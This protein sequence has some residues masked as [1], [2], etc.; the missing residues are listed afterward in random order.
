MPIETQTER[1]AL[2]R[3]MSLAKYQDAKLSIAE[4]DTFKRI[5]E[6]IGWDSGT[7]IDIF[8]DDATGRARE[9]LISDDATAAF[10]DEQTKA[11]TDA[12]ARQTSLSKIESVLKADG[13]DPDEQ[14]FIAWIRNAW[15]ME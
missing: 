12:A 5:I 14:P 3:L 13:I 1:E 6:D 11:F 10:I 7:T 8:I 4:N 2:I 15:G 9:A